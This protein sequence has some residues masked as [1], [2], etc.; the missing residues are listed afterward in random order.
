MPLPPQGRYESVPE[1]VYHGEEWSASLNS[2]SVGLILRSPAHY[3]AA[4]EFPLEPTPA[5]LLG[6]A[7]H[8]AILQPDELLKNFTGPEPTK[9]PGKDFDRRTK[10]GKANYERWTTAVLDPWVETHG[11]KTRLTETE[12]GHLPGIAASIDRTPEARYVLG[13]G[14]CE[15]S[16]V[17]DDP[18]TG[19]TCRCRPDVCGEERNLLVDVKSTTDARPG[20]FSRAIGIYGYA[21]Q[22]AHY[23]DGVNAVLGGGTVTNFV[24]VVVEKVPPY[25]VATYVLDPA[26]VE[27]GRKQNQ[28][29]MR[30]LAWCLKEGKWPG[31]GAKITPIGLTKWDRISIDEREDPQ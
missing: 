28:R 16:F 5:M 26:D 11:D 22:A 30:Q 25:G 2:S 19:I 9:P 3:K 17:W 8:Y 6:R 24:F 1:S 31:Y 7:I 4:R 14:L 21:R 12:W 13:A 10:V 18:A 15:S 29:A 20:P 23:L 27:R